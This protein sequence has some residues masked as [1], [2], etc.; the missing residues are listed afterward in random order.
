VL[1]T[2]SLRGVRRTFTDYSSMRAILWRFRVAF[3]EQDMSM[4]AAFRSELQALL[5]QV[6]AI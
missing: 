1:C 4:D 2:T 5:Y 6:A 3:D